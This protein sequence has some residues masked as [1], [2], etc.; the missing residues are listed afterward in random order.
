MG[1][2]ES[3]RHLFEHELRGT[4]H[5]ENA[6]VDALE[7]TVRDSDLLNLYYLGT[8]MKAERAELTTYDSL[9]MVADRLGL[10]DVTDPLEHNRDSEEDT[11]EQLQMPAASSEAQSLCERFL[12]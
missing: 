6:L 12:S 4:Y 7:A 10:G 9:L 8:G 5:M 3:R 1:K 2:T 11:L